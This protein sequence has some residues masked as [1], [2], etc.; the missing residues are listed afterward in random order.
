MADL[1][2]L[3]T[4]GPTYEPI[5]PVRFIGN[6]S[7]GKM[8]IALAR[9]LAEEGAE[10]NLVL[11]PT[12]IQAESPGIRVH[13]IHTAQQMYES[14]LALFAQSDITIMAAA[15]A[16]FTPMQPADK[17]IKKETLQEDTLNLQ[18]KKTP[19][20]LQELGKRK[21]ENQLLVGFALE[22]EQEQ[23]HAIKKLRE[24]NLDFIVLNSLNEPGAG[25]GYDTNKITIIDRDGHIINHSLKAKYEVARDIVN[26]IADKL[27]RS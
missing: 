19:D 26:F 23:A 3:V 8:G 24:K 4:A 10:V 25:F 11:G 17:K 20:I 14:A 22:T 15:V 6:Y 13:C 16:D 18:L 27:G 2:A 12:S 5:D 21:K 9:A 1:T 7:T